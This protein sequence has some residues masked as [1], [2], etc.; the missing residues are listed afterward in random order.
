[1]ACKTTSAVRASTATITPNVDMHKPGLPSLTNFVAQLCE[2]SNVEVTT[3]VATIVY[4]ER[5]RTRLRTVTQR[6]YGL[7]L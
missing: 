1:M 5:L 4:L 2:D 6:P 3:L 7:R